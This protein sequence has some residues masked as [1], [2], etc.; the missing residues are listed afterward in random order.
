MLVVD[1]NHWVFG[2]DA[3]LP[4]HG[5]VAPALRRILRGEPLLMTAVIQMEVVHYAA[6]ELTE[7]LPRVVEA[8][9]GLPAHAYEPLDA[10]GALASMALMN[11]HRRH[12]IG[13]RDAH[14]L[15]AAKKHRASLL[16]TDDRALAKAA[17]AEGLAVRNLAR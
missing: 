9:F 11:R 7:E 13:S 16:L 3:A 2:L 14:L 10:T 1:T 12:G 17:R 6:R 8:F 4:E 5:A 15:H